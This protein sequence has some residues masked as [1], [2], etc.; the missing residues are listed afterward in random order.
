MI[1]TTNNP[2]AAI[3]DGAMLIYLAVLTSYGLV[4]LFYIIF[5]LKID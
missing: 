5:F 3:M 4:V 1:L 2:L